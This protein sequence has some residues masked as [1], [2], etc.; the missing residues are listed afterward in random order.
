LIS[1]AQ[2]PPDPPSQRT[3]LPI[4]ASFDAV[5]MRCLAKSPDSR[6]ASAEALADELAAIDDLPAWTTAQARAW[7]DVNRPVVVKS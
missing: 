3:E 6:P 5:V 4:P 7:W 1:H 2:T